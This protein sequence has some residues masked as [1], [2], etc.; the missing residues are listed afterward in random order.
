MD[1]ESA[2]QFTD[3]N[4]NGVKDMNAM[5]KP[6]RLVVL[7]LATAG[8]F[9]AACGGD[10]S[11][12]SRSA[13]APTESSPEREPPPTA[14]IIMPPIPP[15]KPQ[16]SANQLA[17]KIELPDF[18]PTDGPVYPDTAPSKAFVKGD[19]VN[20]MFGTPDAPNRVLDF[21][22]GELPR[23]GW[24]NAQVE[25]IKNVIT[26]KAT[27]PGRELTILLTELDAGTSSQTTLIAVSVTS[28]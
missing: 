9:L 4:E 22:N 10:E 25:R 17:A 1:R 13:V 6:T 19:R 20:L 12:G 7:A 2:T 18:Y 3:G 15:T 27:K 11:P 28:G 24:N 8:V 5:K 14:E 21:M 26:M 23:L 16:S